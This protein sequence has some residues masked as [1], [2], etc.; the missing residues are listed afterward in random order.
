[1]FEGYFLTT[2]CFKSCTGAA[3]LS[4]GQDVMFFIL[5]FSP[6][7]KQNLREIVDWQDQVYNNNGHGGARSDKNP[8]K[9]PPNLPYSEFISL[10]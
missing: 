7:F 2:V 6:K 1:M 9:L 3:A 8:L 5:P 10:D 4:F